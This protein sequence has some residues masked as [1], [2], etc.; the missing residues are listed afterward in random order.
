MIEENVKPEWEDENMVRIEDVAEITQIPPEQQPLPEPIVRRNP[1][2]WV[3]E[4]FMWH[5]FTKSQTA[6]KLG[7]S[8]KPNAQER[9]NIQRVA[10]WLEKLR[11][12]LAEKYG[13]PI[14]I[15]IT[16]GFR[17]ERVNRAV[18]GSPT[19][20]HR[21]G[22]AADIQAIGLP[23][24]QLAYDIFDF[25]QRGKLP[26]LDQMIREMPHGGGQWVH[27]GLSQGLHR[28]Q[29]LVYEW[30]SKL[31]KNAYGRVDKFFYQEMVVA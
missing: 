9:V 20:A 10:Q 6:T 13:K 1:D 21:Y 16:S 8:N 29:W 28:G 5:E 22:L 14:P 17:S 19:S 3:S 25:I 7:L 27:I 12:L 11:A 23:I 15:R 31:G 4:N 26:K 30:N 2:D 18:G 24:K